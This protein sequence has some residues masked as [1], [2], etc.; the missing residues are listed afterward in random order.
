MR[1]RI[2]DSAYKVTRNRAGLPDI[3]LYLTRAETE[4]V[5][6]RVTGKT[7]QSFLLRSVDPPL[8]SI[9]GRKSSAFGGLASGASSRWK[10]NCSSTFT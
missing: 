9:E 8:S 4:I 7:R 2:I 10:E 3:L 6:R 5:G 1:R